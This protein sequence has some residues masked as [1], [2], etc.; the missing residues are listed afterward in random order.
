MCQHLPYSDIKINNNISFDDV[1]KASYDADI[2]YMVEVDISFPEH[3][4][5]LLKHM[6]TMSRKYNS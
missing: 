2:G 3:M 4:H 1:I 6:C 5:E